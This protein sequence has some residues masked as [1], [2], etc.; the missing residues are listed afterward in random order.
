MLCSQ[1]AFFAATAEDIRQGLEEV[2]Q[3]LANR[4]ES[5][6]TATANA[7]PGS[8]LRLKKLASRKGMF[9]SVFNR[10]NKALRGCMGSLTPQKANL[11]DEVAHWTAMAMLHDPR[12]SRP[13]L[14]KTNRPAEYDVI[15]SFIEATE[16]VNDPY[17]IN[18]I[19]HGIMVTWQGRSELVLPGEAFTTAY[20]LKIIAAK[21]GLAA[22]PAGAEYFRVHAERFGRAKALFKKIDKGYGG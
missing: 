1:K 8:V 13:A 15:V 21:F 5:G 7:E 16:L 12:G 9:V 20:S 4:L 14:K 6:A 11:Y 3:D 22:I 10:K 17:E 2:A 19:T 18:S